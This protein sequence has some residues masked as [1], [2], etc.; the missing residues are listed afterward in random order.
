[1]R[2]AHLSILLVSVPLAALLLA[3]C[4]AVTATTQLQRET[5]KFIVDN[6]GGVLPPE[7]VMISEVRGI[8]PGEIQWKADTMQAKYDCSADE[9]FHRVYC[10]E[11]D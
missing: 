2:K 8:G 10:A 7:F 9:M 6:V 5:A 11:G 1:M 4:T 3:G